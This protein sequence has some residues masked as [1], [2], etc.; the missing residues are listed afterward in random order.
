MRNPP[1]FTALSAPELSRDGKHFA[2][3]VETDTG[4]NLD[5][6]IPLDE[7]GAI[8]EFL[9]SVANHAE[10]APHQGQQSL[11]PIPIQGLGFAAGNSP[12]ETLLVVRLVG[13]DLAFSLAS[14]KVAA[15]GNEFSRIAQAL[16]A[17]GRPQ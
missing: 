1:R 5:L 8:V 11:S 3:V 9:I 16:A 13:C 12:E 6:E 4:E 17:S 14:S 7:V 2:V 15:L 10:F